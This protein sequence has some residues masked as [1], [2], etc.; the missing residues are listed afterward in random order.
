MYTVLK[1]DSINLGYF[2]IIYFINV[3]YEYVHSHLRVYRVL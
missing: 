3:Y 1:L 2:H